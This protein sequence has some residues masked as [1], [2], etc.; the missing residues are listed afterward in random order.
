LIVGANEVWKISKP[1]FLEI[2]FRALLLLGFLAIARG[3]WLLV[4]GYF[5]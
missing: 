1:A 5:R 3:F 4:K 2:T